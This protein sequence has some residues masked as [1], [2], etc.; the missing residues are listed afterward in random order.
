MTVLDRQH[1]REQV[2]ERQLRLA[3]DRAA[4]YGL[5]QPCRQAMAMSRAGCA[6]RARALHAECTAEEAG[7]IGCLCLCHDTRETAVISGFAA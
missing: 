2:M 4:E 3:V 1:L 6:D 7:G 5:S